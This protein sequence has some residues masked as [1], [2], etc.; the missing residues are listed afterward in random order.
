MSS[1]LVNRLSLLGEPLNLTINSYNST[2]VVETQRNKFTVSSEPNNND[3]VF[4]LGAYLKES[5]RIGSELIKSLSGRK[6]FYN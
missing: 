2:T 1:F 5:I 3:F 4:T 6:N